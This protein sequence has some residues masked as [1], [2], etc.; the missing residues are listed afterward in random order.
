M[1]MFPIFAGIDTSWFLAANIAM[2]NAMW[3]MIKER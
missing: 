3:L 2:L 1:G